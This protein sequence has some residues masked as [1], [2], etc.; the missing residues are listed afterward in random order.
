MANSQ[1]QPVLE[2]VSRRGCPP[3]TR[4][5]VYIGKTIMDNRIEVN[6]KTKEQTYYPAIPL[7]GIYP[8]KYSLQ[9]FK[10]LNVFVSAQF[11]IAK[12]W[13]QAQCP[14]RDEWIR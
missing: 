5:V 4:M 11:T 7:L 8:E 13:K 1:K 9:K 14:L 6:P 10:G 2:R 12:T 3:T